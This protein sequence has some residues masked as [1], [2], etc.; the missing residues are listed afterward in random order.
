MKMKVKFILIFILV[1]LL[2]STPIFALAGKESSK[3]IKE[4]TRLIKYKFIHFQHFEGVKVEK[5]DS[6][7]TKSVDARYTGG[8][9][10]NNKVIEFRFSEDGDKLGAIAHGETS[11]WIKKG[12][13]QTGLIVKKYKNRLAQFEYDHTTSVMLADELK[14]KKE[15]IQYKNTNIERMTVYLGKNGVY[16]SKKVRIKCS[17]PDQSCMAFQ[18]IEYGDGTTYSYLNV[19]GSADMYKLED[20]KEKKEKKLRLDKVAGIRILSAKK[21][22]V[23]FFAKPTR[24]SN[25]YGSWTK[26]KTTWGSPYLYKYSFK[27]TKTEI[28]GTRLAVS[29]YSDGTTFK[30]KKKKRNSFILITT[31]QD[32]LRLEEGTFTLNADYPSYTT[33]KREKKNCVYRS[34]KKSYQISLQDIR[35]PLKLNIIGFKTSHRRIRVDNLEGKNK[36]YVLGRQGRLLFENQ[37]VDVIGSRRPWHYYKSSFIRTIEKSGKKY[38]INCDARKKVCKVNDKLTLKE[39]R[40]WT[41]NS[42]SSCPNGEKCVENICILYNGVGCKPYITKGNKRAK[43]D[44]LVIGDGYDEKYLKSLIDLLFFHRTQGAFTKKILSEHKNKFNIYTLSYKENELPRGK[45]GEPDRWVIKREKFRHCNFADQI[46]VLS[47]KSFRSYAS[48]NLVQLSNHFGKPLVGFTLAHEFGHSIGKLGDEYYEWND[49]ISRGTSINC[50]KTKAEAERKFGT[51]LWQGCGGK[52]I[53]G[54]DRC[55]KYYRPSFLSIMK[56]TII[57]DFDSFGYRMMSKNLRRYS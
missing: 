36:F 47:P 44:L 7:F 11:P 14:F 16:E 18:I 28:R 26:L 2:V 37:N 42:D 49:K 29:S 39:S 52:C 32:K 40:I 27:T 51:S 41:C 10:D 19:Y 53:K 25:I 57:G 17:K 8:K 33:C 13:Q 6:S 9:R 31:Y 15:I 55:D 50:V 35:N 34:S 4:G 5:R 1:C 48:G 43:L 38:K 30:I 3:I 56:Q 22:D 12:K 23:R 45:R 46:V 24:S 54:K 20:G 21:D